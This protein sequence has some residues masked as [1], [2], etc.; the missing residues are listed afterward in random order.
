MKKINN[1]TL[2]L[3]IGLIASILWIFL[4]LDFGFHFKAY[5]QFCNILTLFGFRH[6]IISILVMIMIPLCACENII[7]IIGSMI[8][9][10]ITFFLTATHIVYLIIIKQTEYIFGPVIWL[11]IHITIIISAYLSYKEL[12]K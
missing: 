8:T 5:D 12:N 3:I 11:L 10:I 7:G 6:T 9:G 1:Y 4:G 2:G